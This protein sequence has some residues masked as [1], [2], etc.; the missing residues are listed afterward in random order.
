MSEERVQILNMLRDGKITVEEADRLLE[1]VNEQARP[2]EGTA[3]VGGGKARFLQV[4]V[5]EEGKSKVNVNLPLSLAKL[6]MRFIP[7]AALQAGEHKIDIEEILAAI[8]QGA[9][10]KLVEV[11]DG[12]D[13]VEIIVTN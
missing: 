1:A 4:R 11:E 10:G 9:G 12:K 7:R 6:A 5:W 3:E 8:Q 2:A 13:R